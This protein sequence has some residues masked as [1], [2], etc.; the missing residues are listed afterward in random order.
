MTAC[1][2]AHQKDGERWH[3]YHGSKPCE[4]ARARRRLAEAHRDEARARALA[5][6]QAELPPGE[7]ARRKWRPGTAILVPEVDPC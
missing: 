7:W 6:A 2:C 4:A 5:L 1:G 3:R